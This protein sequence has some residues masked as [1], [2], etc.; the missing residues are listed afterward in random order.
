MLRSIF[1]CF[2]CPFAGSPVDLSFLPVTDPSAH[3]ISPAPA[4]PMAK[5]RSFWQRRMVDPIIAQI[6]QG[7]TPDRIAFTLAVGSGVSMFPFLGFTSLLNLAVG[8]RLRLNQPI[9]QTLNQLLGPLH[10]IMI[11][12]YVRVGE[13]IWGAERIPFS[14]P[15]LLDT[16]RHQPISEFLHRF[17][18]ASIHALTAW[19]I[20]LPLIIL[21]LN[22]I[23][24]PILRKLA[25]PLRTRS[26]IPRGFDG[27]IS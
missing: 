7:V 18:W 1:W 20:S 26:R 17:G 6:T 25:E 3:L 13:A 16:L 15:V 14:I 23:L 10:L 8:L 2:R 4:A 5:P 19:V 21:P 11:I 22:V 24:R 27:E 9:L 12:I